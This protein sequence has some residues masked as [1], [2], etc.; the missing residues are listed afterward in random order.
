MPMKTL[1]K[2]L[3]FPHSQFIFHSGLLLVFSASLAS[4]VSGFSST[5]TEIGNFKN[6]L[7]QAASRLRR[8][9]LQAKSKLEKKVLK[10]DLVCLS[11]Q[12]RSVSFSFLAPPK[13]P[14]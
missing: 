5:N 9:C 3:E 13:T 10:R 4:R 1:G 6:L 14:S 11:G 7:G 2:R 8:E 12:I